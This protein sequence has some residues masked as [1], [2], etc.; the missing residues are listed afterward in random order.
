VQIYIGWI[1]L[2][3]GGFLFLAQVISSVNF[4]FA[5]RLGIQEAPEASDTLLQT[6]E[7]YAAYW[8]LV[9]LGW[10]PLAGILMIYDHAW[11]QIVA[12]IGGA[13]Y[14]DASGREAAKN[15]SFKKEGIRLGTEKQ[16]KMFFC[17]YILMAII[18]VA[19]IGYS[20]WELTSYV[21]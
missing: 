1:L 10:L 13:I 5:Q 15:I 3:L 21:K 19:L 6:A 20:A 11:W 4:G 16:Q 7:R 2:I 18:G 12:L 14:Y 8:D 9:T 17:S